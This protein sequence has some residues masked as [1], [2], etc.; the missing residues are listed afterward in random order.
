VADLHAVFR[1]PP[2]CANRLSAYRCMSICVHIV[3]GTTP[4]LEA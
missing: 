3:G 4:L 1:L 2:P